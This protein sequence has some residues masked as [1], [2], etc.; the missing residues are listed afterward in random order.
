M[1]VTLTFCFLYSKNKLNGKIFDNNASVL[2]TFYGNYFLGYTVI[3]L[4]EHKKMHKKL[5]N[6]RFK[7][8]MR[9]IMN[10]ILIL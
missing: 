1:L 7:N 10:N 6:V 3:A 8:M 5:L 9:G 4:I 2:C